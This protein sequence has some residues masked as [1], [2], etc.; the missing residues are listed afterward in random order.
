M[1]AARSFERFACLRASSI[2]AAGAAF[3]KA[4]RTL[5][6]AAP[7]LSLQ[8]T[9]AD[10]ALPATSIC[11]C[12]RAEAQNAVQRSSGTIPER[13]S[14]TS[15]IVSAPPKLASSC[16]SASDGS[17][18]ASATSDCGSSTLRR[19]KWPAG[20]GRSDFSAD[21]RESGIFVP[22][23]SR[24]ITSSAGFIS[25]SRPAPRPGRK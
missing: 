19:R 6:S 10:F 13:C 25:V 4:F 2:R 14:L 18:S 8:E 21:T 16:R 9:F 11:L 22:R 17:D 1:K 3:S 20:S 7:A 5:S 24:R 12:L 23:M 15:C